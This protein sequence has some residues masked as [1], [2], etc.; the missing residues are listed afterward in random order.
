M[1]PPVR[2][3]NFSNSVRV[4]ILT[5][6]V[7]WYGTGGQLL[8]DGGTHHILIVPGDAA[9]GTDLLLIVP[10]DAGYSTDLLLIV[11]GDAG[12]GTDLLLIVPGDAG[13]GPHHLL[14]VPEDAG[15]G[16]HHL[17]IVPGDAGLGTH[18][19]LIVPWDAGLGIHHLVIV[20]GDAGLGTDHLLIVPGDDGL[21]TH[22]FLIVPGDTGL[23]THHLLIVPGDAG[24]CIRLFLLPIQAGLDGSSR[25]HSKDGVRV[26]RGEES[27]ANVT[28]H[29]LAGSRG[30]LPGV[31]FDDGSFHLLDS[32]LE[33][34]DAV[35]V[36]GPFLSHQP[37]GGNSRRQAHTAVTLST[38]PVLDFFSITVKVVDEVVSI[39]SLFSA[40]RSGEYPS[41]THCV[42]QSLC[43]TQI[44]FV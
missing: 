37:V 8:W 1:T 3:N 33:E 42:L 24:Y 39:P 36:L 40:P 25:G 17:V 22:H 44:G 41:D 5:Y 6:L 10:G 7:S 31:L 29:L 21:G 14:I 18:H 16:S 11:P 9:H 27:V 13:H 32:P 38:D 20:P 28:Q 4:H 26:L 12:H 34:I 2:R 19:L 43:Q 30:D 15:L 35:V 23:G